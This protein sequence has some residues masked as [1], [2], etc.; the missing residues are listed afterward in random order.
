MRLC[1]LFI[2]RFSL[3]TSCTHSVM[4]LS[5][6]VIVNNLIKCTNS[7]INLVQLRACGLLCK[8]TARR[9][10]TE[11]ILTV[12]KAWSSYNYNG[13]YTYELI[14]LKHI[15]VRSCIQGSKCKSGKFEKIELSKSEKSR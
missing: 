14:L 2:S 7:P 1:I 3:N 12:D 4:R 6:I 8:E 5:R 11:I 15:E 10:T 9:Y 13:L